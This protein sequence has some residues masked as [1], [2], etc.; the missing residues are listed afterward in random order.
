M[1]VSTHPAGHSIE[2]KNSFRCVQLG[3]DPSR[4]GFVILKSENAEQPDIELNEK[5]ESQDQRYTVIEFVQL[6][7]RPLNWVE[8]WESNDQ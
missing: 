3:K 4:P 2:F 7:D 1:P 8:P 5:G 6:L